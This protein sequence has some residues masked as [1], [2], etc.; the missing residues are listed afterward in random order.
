M[1]SSHFKLKL[2]YR[3]RRGGKGEGEGGGRG[4]Y[5]HELTIHVYVSS[6]YKVAKPQLGYVKGRS[7]TIV[8]LELLG[9]H[10]H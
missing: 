3:G 10:P 7:S 4:A 5:Y 1:S 2:V 8:P 9:S 6:F